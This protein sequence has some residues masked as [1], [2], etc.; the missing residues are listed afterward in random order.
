[1]KSKWIVL[2]CLVLSL[3]WIPTA[4]AQGVFVV[5]PTGV[6]DTA[7]LQAA[8]NAAVAAGPGRAPPSR[9]SI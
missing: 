3:A 6:D 9:S 7:N 5:T 4:G 2:C 1:M 8:F